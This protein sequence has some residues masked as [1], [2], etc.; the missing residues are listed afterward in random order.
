MKNKLMLRPIHYASVS[1]G[2]DSLFMLKLILE[3]PDKYPLDMVVNFDLEIEWDWEKKVV[4]YIE[5]ECNRLGIKFVKIKPTHSWEYYVNKYSMPNRVVRWCNSKYKLSCE[6]Q[7]K[8]W[9]KSL[10]CRP[11]AYIG[12]CADETKR[13]KYDI[14]DWEDKDICY[15]IA[16]E[17]ITEDIILE[18]AKTQPIFENWYKHFPRGGCMCCPLCRQ[19]EFAYL[20]IKAPEKYQYFRKYIKEYEEKFKRPWRVGKFIEELEEFVVKKYKPIIEKE[21]KDLEI[22]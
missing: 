4:N 10:N 2:K 13:F 15:P 18:W 17:G 12:L 11:I 14:G 3:N 5:N 7:L 22:K 21:E 19:K 1:G 16:E 9:I 8:D 20:I 6:K